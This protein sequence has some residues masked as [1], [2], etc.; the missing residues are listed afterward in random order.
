MM[1]YHGG[2]SED[3][4]DNRIESDVRSWECQ[5]YETLHQPHSNQFI[6][7]PPLRLTKLQRLI[8]LRKYNSLH[9]LRMLLQEMG[10]CLSCLGLNRSDSEQVCDYYISVKP[11][12]AT[13]PD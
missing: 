7:L 5:P 11:F 8:A 12:R 3:V 4:S 10:S 1:M 9:S 6:H 13:H 2:T